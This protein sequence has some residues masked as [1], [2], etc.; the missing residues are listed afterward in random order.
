[1]LYKSHLDRFTLPFNS[2]KNIQ[3]VKIKI[4]LRIM[5]KYSNIQMLLFSLI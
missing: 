5:E 2:N 3:I 1:M 4:I